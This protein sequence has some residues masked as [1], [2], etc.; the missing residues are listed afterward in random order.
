MIFGEA[1][2]ESET[3]N[4][5]RVLEAIEFFFLDGEKKG[6]VVKQSDC[7]TTAE[8]GNAENV[9]GESDQVTPESARVRD[10]MGEAKSCVPSMWVTSASRN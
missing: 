8:S 2:I 5:E 10:S 7:G 3:R 6:G 4:I 1:A 9:H